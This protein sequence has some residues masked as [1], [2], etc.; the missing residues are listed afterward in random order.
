MPVVSSPRSLSP[1]YSVVVCYAAAW[2]ARS[3]Q[4][5]REWHGRAHRSRAA[6]VAAAADPSLLAVTVPV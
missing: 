4:R 5:E 1:K 3:S 6:A 2:G